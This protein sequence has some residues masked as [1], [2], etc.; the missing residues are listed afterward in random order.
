MLEG[1]SK[2]RNVTADCEEFFFLDVMYE[3]L[4]R[5]VTPWS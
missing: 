5:P 2:L 1:S 4:F 3:T